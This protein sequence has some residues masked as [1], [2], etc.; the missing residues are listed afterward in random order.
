VFRPVMRG[1][2]FL[3]RT[4][5]ARSRDNRKNTTDDQGTMSGDDVP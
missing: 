2:V 1:M 3:Y 4:R 5:F